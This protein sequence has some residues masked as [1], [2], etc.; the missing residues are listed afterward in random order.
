MGRVMQVSVEF[1]GRTRVLS[2]GRELAL[3]RQSIS[4]LA[5]LVL[6]RELDHP[7]EV[8]IEPFW[9]SHETSARGVVSEPRYPDCGRDSVLRHTIGRA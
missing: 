7:R 6:Y 3:S 8:M 1:L 9:S 2:R 5:Y 4:F